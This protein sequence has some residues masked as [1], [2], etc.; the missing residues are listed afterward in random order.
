MIVINDWKERA[1][2]ICWEN[3]LHNYYHEN[4]QNKKY[5]LMACNAHIE[6]RRSSLW[7]EII[8]DRLYISVWFTNAEYV[9][10]PKFH[11]NAIA[12]TIFF[13]QHT[14][15]LLILS[16]VLLKREHVIFMWREISQFHL[17]F[18][19]YAKNEYAKLLLVYFQNCKR[20]ITGSLTHFS[21]L[22]H[23]YTPWKRQKT[24]CFQGV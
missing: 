4:V 13:A 24:F 22:S 21:P 9:I 11:R 6:I 18:P 2:L 17:S 5:Q 3:F 10:P 20:K 23:I 1:Q 12:L 7:K 8:N 16:Y 19:G 14:S 15:T